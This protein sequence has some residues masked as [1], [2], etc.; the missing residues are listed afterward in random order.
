MDISEEKKDIKEDD[1][2][3]EDSLEERKIE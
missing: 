3:D 2:D 1:E